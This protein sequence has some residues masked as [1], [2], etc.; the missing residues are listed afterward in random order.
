MSSEFDGLTS[1]VRI[2][3]ALL[4]GVE[5]DDDK[6]DSWDTVSVQIAEF[7]A[8]KLTTEEREIVKMAGTEHLYRTYYV[9]LILLFYYENVSCCNG[10]AIIF[11]LGPRIQEL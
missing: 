9:C 7:D 10:S 1:Y 2:A 8:S 6:E 3:R 5:A 11:I 4:S